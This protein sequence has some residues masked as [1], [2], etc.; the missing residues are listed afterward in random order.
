MSS[1]R[2]YRAKWVFPSNNEPLAD[3][4][5]L[6]E[7]TTI[8]GITTHTVPG[9]VDLGNAALIPGLVNAHVHLEFGHLSQPIAPFAPF[10]DWIRRVVA[11]R[12]AAGGSIAEHLTRSIREV[13]TS[14]TVALGEIAT[15]PASLDC[16]GVSGL[17]G[18]VFQEMIGPLP[19]MIGQRLRDAEEAARRCRLAGGEL[20]PGISPHAPYT[21]HPDLLDRLTDF[22]VEH[23]LPLAM[24]LAETPAELRLLETGAGEFRELLRSLDL[25]PGDVWRNW[26]R[27]GDYLRR[28]A[29]APRCLVVHGNYLDDDAIRFLASQPQI[30]VAYCPRTHA[31]F[32]H[33]PHPWQRLLAQGVN[34]CLG[35]DGRSSNPDLE[36]WKEVQFLHAKHPQVPGATLLR[37][38]TEMGGTALGLGESRPRMAIG[39]TDRLTVIDPLP[40][41]VSDP[42]AAIFSRAAT[43]RPL[44]SDVS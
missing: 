27:V 12:R 10:T 31:N 18:V 9:A 35:T 23:N 26:R 20:R 13:R 8:T 24:H 36:L 44:S 28:V 29:A 15:S 16:L 1:V 3:A 19:E 32:G 40:R 38:A 11:A 22:A 43:A 30:S 37:M 39:G 25:W 34:V 4:T 17:Q 6:L 33:P 5:V 21:V 41:G 42:Y 2:A 7:G 14:G